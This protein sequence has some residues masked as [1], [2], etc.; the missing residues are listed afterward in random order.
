MFKVQISKTEVF[1]KGLEL[2]LRAESDHIQSIFDRLSQ[3]YPRLPEE[4]LHQVEDTC[5]QALEL[6]NEL[7]D[8]VKTMQ[9]GQ[10]PDFSFIENRIVDH[11]P[12][13]SQ[14]NLE[15][16]LGDMLPGNNKAG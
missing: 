6:G 15:R 3:F 16:L 1:N 2:S 12:W 11:Y 13:I 9:A 7:M 14:K 8:Q 10:T 4:R 5:R